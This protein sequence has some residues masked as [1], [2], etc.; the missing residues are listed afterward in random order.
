MTSLESSQLSLLAFWLSRS[1]CRAYFVMSRENDSRSVSSQARE[2]NRNRSRCQVYLRPT[3]NCD[4]ALLHL[5]DLQLRFNYA[6][7]ALTRM[8][9]TGAKVT[10]LSISIGKRS[11]GRKWNKMTT[12]HCRSRSRGSQKRQQQQQQQQQQHGV[13]NLLIRPL[14][15]D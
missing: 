7:S 15:H 13:T 6:S 3:L 9:I 10:P 5:P 4:V 1:K 11:A 8:K 12:Q 14:S 2:K